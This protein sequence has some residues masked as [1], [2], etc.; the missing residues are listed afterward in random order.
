M[1]SFFR[2]LCIQ[3]HQTLLTINKDIEITSTVSF[4]K[5]VYSPAALRSQ[6]WTNMHQQSNLFALLQHF[7]RY[8]ASRR[9]R[10]PV[11]SLSS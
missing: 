10:V 5:R 4:R 11:E 3:T 1:N 2:T 8:V 6:I 7:P 9:R